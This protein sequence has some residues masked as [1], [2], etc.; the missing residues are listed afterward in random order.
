MSFAMI[1]GSAGSEQAFDRIV[2]SLVHP[3]ERIDVPASAILSIEARKERTYVLE[4]G[5]RW[6][7]RDHRVELCFTPEIHHRIGVFTADIVDEVLEVVV[8]G[9]CIA[10]PIVRA[11]LKDL[12]GF[13]I[14]VWDEADTRALCDKLRAAWGKARRALSQEAPPAKNGDHQM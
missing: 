10:A 2:L 14:S 1:A 9:E 12:T 13:C 6:T 7:M 11:P 5:V 3:R 8:A 4:T